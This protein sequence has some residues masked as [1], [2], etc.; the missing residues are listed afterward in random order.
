MIKLISNE[1]NTKDRRRREN[2]RKRET[3]R[4]R[5]SEWVKRRG[6]KAK[7]GEEKKR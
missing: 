2:V 3:E 4:E 6:K 1:G 7:A 5:L